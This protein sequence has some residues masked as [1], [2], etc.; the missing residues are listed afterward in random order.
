MTFLNGITNLTNWM[1]NVIMPTVAG[2]FFALAVIRYAR[3][4]PHQYIAWSGLMCLMISGLL[5]GL[6][7]FASQSAWNNP[8][9]DLDHPPRPRELV[10]ATSSCLCMPSCRLSRASSHTEESATVFTT[11]A[12]G[13]DTLPRRGWRCPYPVCCD[14]RSSSSGEAPVGSVEK[15]IKSGNRRHQ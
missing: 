9:T 5:R 12:P 1:G 4:Y 13:S 10:R 2:L 11:E 3:G 15:A 6:E 8:D 14:S 7:T